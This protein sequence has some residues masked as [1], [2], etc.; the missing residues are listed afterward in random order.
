MGI[1]EG[2]AKKTCKM[3]CASLCNL[4]IK[5]VGGRGVAV[6]K[7]KGCVGVFSFASKMSPPHRTKKEKKRKEKK[8]NSGT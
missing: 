1:R 2:P 4:K 8:I 7:E 5:S 6:A 3:A